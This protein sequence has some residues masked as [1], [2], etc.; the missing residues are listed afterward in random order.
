MVGETHIAS[1]ATI[2]SDSDAYFVSQQQKVPEVCGSRCLPSEADYANRIAPD[3]RMPMTFRD[4]VLLH[5]SGHQ[6]TGGTA[7]RATYPEG[8][9]GRG[10]SGGQQPGAP[11]LPG[12]RLC[13]RRGGPF[14]SESATRSRGAYPGSS[15]H[16]DLVARTHSLSD[17]YPACRHRYLPGILSSP[18]PP[19]GAQEALCSP[20][21]DQGYLR[22]CFKAAY[23]LKEAVSDALEERQFTNRLAHANRV[24]RPV[25]QGPEDS[26]YESDGP[27][28][29]LPGNYAT[30]EDPGVR[31][32]TGNREGWLE[33]SLEDF[34]EYAEDVFSDATINSLPPFR[35]GYDCRITLKDGARLYHRQSL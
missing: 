4:G 15:R 21:H 29:P 23:Q 22:A 35:P 11:V 34:R 19:S 13:F 1:V 30:P 5:H 17:L 25:D 6:T 24:H 27:T 16:S 2:V 20:H 9:A 14:L 28:H 12:D 31:G 32:L 3:R 18:A 8:S 10:R 33:S 26:G 7:Q